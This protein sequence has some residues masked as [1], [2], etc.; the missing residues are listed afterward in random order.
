MND[1]SILPEY[2]RKDLLKQSKDAALT[3]GINLNLLLDAYD[4]YVYRYP[5]TTKSQDFELADLQISIFALGLLP[6]SVG[7]ILNAWTANTTGILS[8]QGFELNVLNEFNIHMNTVFNFMIRKEINLDAFNIDDVLEAF[9]ALRTANR[10]LTP[11]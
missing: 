9:L 5:S 7:E 2:L 3:L 10:I 11:I 6:I 1:K 4:F 8:R